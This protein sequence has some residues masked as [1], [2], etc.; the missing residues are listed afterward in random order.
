MILREISGCVLFATCIKGHLQAFSQVYGCKRFYISPSQGLNFVR[1]GFRSHFCVGSSQRYHLSLN[2]QS[3]TRLGC[4]WL[5]G[6]SSACLFLAVKREDVRFVSFGFG[7]I[8]LKIDECTIDNNFIT[9]L[10]LV[11]CGELGVT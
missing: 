11:V 8:T 2:R 10:N 4:F 1:Y 6:S 7:R 9:H 3:F 5:L